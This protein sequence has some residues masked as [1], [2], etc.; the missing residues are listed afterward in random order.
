MAV[1]RV[2]P[3]QN[4]RSQLRVRREALEEAASVAAVPKAAEEEVRQ[5]T[6][7]EIMNMAMHLDEV[8]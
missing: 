2:K 7:E 8:S 6:F 4:I 3:G 5:P 1:Q